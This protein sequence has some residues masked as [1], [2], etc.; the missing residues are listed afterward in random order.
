MTQ[1][2][3][4]T[5]GPPVQQKSGNGFGV[6]ALVLGIIAI[7]LA[8]IP[9]VGIVAF[10]LGPIAIIL[11]IVGVTKKY[12][13]K[14]TSIAGII[15][16]AIGLIVAIIMTAIVGSFVNAIDEEVNNGSTGTVEE[17]SAPAAED[18]VPSEGGASAEDAAQ[19]AF[20]GAQESDV[21]GQAG[22][23]LQLG[24]VALTSSPLAAGDATFGDTLCT[25][26]SVTNNAEEAIDFN[27][28]DWE[29][30]EPGGTIQN[31]TFGGSEDALSGG[32]IAP[33]GNT[34]GDV[35]FDSDGADPGT[36][37]VLYEPT[38][39]FT[40]DRAAWINER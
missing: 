40:S 29:M 18:E 25:T 17:S 2:P 24:N 30:Q 20:P 27:M 36:Y 14:G 26:V 15:L 9:V 4:E 16:G 33:G 11:G 35:C 19:P 13:P 10:V 22:D 38:F 12:R 6:A 37:V 3:N 34:G 21:I 32:K 1:H 23:E 5:Y 39:S 7:V 28:L 31:G 8:F